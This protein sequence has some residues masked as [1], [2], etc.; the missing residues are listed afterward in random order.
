MQAA[1]FQFSTLQMANWVLAGN[2]SVDL[3]TLILTQSAPDCVGALWS[4]FSVPVVNGFEIQLTFIFDQ[5]SK[6][7]LV[8]DI[9]NVSLNRQNE[10]CL[11]SGGDGLA[12]VLQT[13]LA[14][15]QSAADAGSLVGELGS[16]L[17]FKNLTDQAVVVEIDTNQNG[18]LGDVDDSHIAF[19]ATGRN[20]S[21][22]LSSDHFLQGIA[23]R[24]LPLYIKDGGLHTL[25]IAFIPFFMKR[26]VM[27]PSYSSSPRSATLLQDNQKT[28]RAMMRQGFLVAYLDDILQPALVSPMEMDQALDLLGGTDAYVGVIAATGQRFHRTRIT[29]FR[30]CPMDILNATQAVDWQGHYC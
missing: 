29:A 3:S 24:T 9:A 23:L 18:D 19:L 21:S 12:V 13:Q 8:T 16:G 22:P 14:P 5:L 11:R 10:Y 17:G 15:T 28:G 7:C 1:G 25:R 30:F 26:L 2:A 4:P 6:N 20:S 27:Q